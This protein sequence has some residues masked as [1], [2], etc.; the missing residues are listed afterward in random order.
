MGILAKP[1]GIT[2]QEH[3]N[4]VLEEGNYI[5]Q[6]FLI[7]FEKYLKIT[8]KDLGKRLNGAIK[9]HDDG[10]A[11]QKWQEACQKDYKNYLD[12]RKTHKGSFED[13]S[14]SCKD[15]AGKSLRS[16]GIRHEISSLDKHFKDGFSEPVK[17]AIAAHHSKLSRKHER[18]W[19]DNSSGS[20]SSKL[21]SE[22]ISLNGCFRNFHDFDKAVIKHYE[23]SGV[24]SFLELSDHRASA[25]EENGAM[26]KFSP[27]SYNFPQEW[28]KRNVQKIAEEHANDDLLLLRAPTGAGK[29]DACLLWA[30]KQIK[31]EKAERLIIAMPTRFTSNALAINVAGTLSETGLYHSS[32]W[33]TKFHKGIKSGELDKTFARKKHELARQL[34]SPVTVCTIDHLLMSLTLTREEHHSIVFNLANSCVVIDEADFYD[35]FTQA[36]ILVLLKALK[37]LSVPVMIM[38]ASLPESSI[39]MYKSVGYRIDSIKEDISD[40][41]RNRCEVKEIKEYENLTEIEDILNLCLEE[42]KAIIY[43]NTVAKAIELYNWFFDRGIKPILYHSRYTEPHK[44]EKEQILLGALGKE[45][46]Q[47]GTAKGI[48]ILTQIGEMSVNISAD[49]MI[50]ELCPIDRLVQRVG[51]LCR[52]DEHKIGKLYVLIPK[53]KGS[54]YPAPYGNYIPRKG[55]DANSAL[56]KTL[57]ILKIKQYSAKDFVEMV[58]QVY[59]KFNQFQSKAIQNANLLKEKFVFNWVILPLE[60]SKEDDTDNQEWRSRD[61]VGNETVFIEYP[62]TDYFYFWQDYQEFKLENSIDVSS[63]LIKRGIKDNKIIKKKIKVSGDD[64]EIYVALNCYSFEYGLQLSKDSKGDQFL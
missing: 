8:Q 22:F 36:N 62:E 4:H 35:E 52:F 41:E 45:A 20:N 27:F 46:W 50:S 5:K 16:S 49:I 28:K 51:R 40:I 2:L 53:Q 38:S 37:V 44:K 11:N 12:W 64:L 15:L 34:L 54:I 25:K 43:A 26:V 61:I 63:Y 42:E 6:S 58:N 21:W 3:V 57:E 13:F 17:V 56:L 31:N 59:P 23:Y 7:S 9:F 29:T 18:R 14:K 1:S 48:A 39:A 32:A 24:R 60:Q 55:W 30:S 19:T 33:F 47:N 10:K